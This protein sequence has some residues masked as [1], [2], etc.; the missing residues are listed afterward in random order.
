MGAAAGTAAEADGLG[1]VAW[2]FRGTGRGAGRLS[3]AVPLVSER[4]A[5]GGVVVTA[6]AG[7]SANSGK[8]FSRK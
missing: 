2:I 4:V 6:G 8:P 5:P 3:I 1:F 7:S